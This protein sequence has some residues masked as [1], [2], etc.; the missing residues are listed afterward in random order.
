MKM[1]R[2]DFVKTAG[3]ATAVSLVGVPHLA[4]GAAKKVVIVGG[5]TAG[6]TAAK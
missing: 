4:F 2:R 3:A 1:N 5:G 6:A